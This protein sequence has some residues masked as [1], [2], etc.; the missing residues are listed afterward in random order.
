MHT[1]AA[2]LK[3]VL[4]G[5]VADVRHVLHR[6]YETRS[7]CLLGK[8]KKAVDTYTYARHSSTEVRCCGFAVDDQPVRLWLPGDPVPPEFVEAANSPHWRAVAHNASFE[9]MIERYILAPRYG[10]PIIP[11]E[12]NICTDAMALSLSLPTTLEQVAEALELAHRKDIA[13]SKL[14]L[15]MC[16]PRKAR[17]GE[18]P[19][20]IYW[21]DEDEEKLARLY[22]YCRQ[23]VEVE[24]EIYKRLSDVVAI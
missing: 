17:K 21:P 16:K 12:R 1:P 2:N 4:F 22:E 7:V 14:M 19:A 6:D 8:E 3:S 5:T 24:R 9:M 11:L 23:D 20:Q 10:F 15:S 13:G 18:D